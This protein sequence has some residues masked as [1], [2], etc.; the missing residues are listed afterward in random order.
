MIV[1]LKRHRCDVKGADLGHTIAIRCMQNTSLIKYTCNYQLMIFTQ[2][3]LFISTCLIVLHLMMFTV[4][5]A[6]D[7]SSPTIIH[8]PGYCVMRGEKVYTKTPKLFNQPAPAPVIHI[9]LT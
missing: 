9:S 5:A 4:V 1:I 8:K 3:A 6:S 2:R 7:S